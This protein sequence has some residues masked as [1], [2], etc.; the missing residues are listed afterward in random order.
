MRI[1]V[2]LFAIA[3]AAPARADEAFAFLHEPPKQVPAGQSIELIGELYGAAL[4]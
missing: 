2:L 3:L 1:L 4:I